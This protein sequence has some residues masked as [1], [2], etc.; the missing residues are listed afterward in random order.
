MSNE[1]QDFELPEDIFQREEIAKSMCELICSAPADAIS[2]VVLQGPWGSG[3]STHA[4]RMMEH[5]NKNYTETH[6]CIYWNA[7]SCDYAADPLP[8]FVANLYSE[9]AS[10]EQK[11][12]S[13]VGFKLCSSTAWA[14]S[15]ELVKQA[16]EKKYGLD[17]SK[18]E[19]VAQQ[20]QNETESLS[21]RQFKFF[22]EEAGA[23]KKRIDAAK[24][25]LNLARGDREL[26]VIIDELDR[27]RPDF[28]LQMIETI[29]H[30][31]TNE[32][33][34]FLLILNKQ[35]L[36]DSIRNIHGL[37]EINAE[38]YLNKFIKTTLQLPHL[39]LE[40][41]SSIDYNSQY[42]FH[43]MSN[44]FKFT[45]PIDLPELVLALIKNKK[46]QLR[47]IEKWVKTITN[48][49]NINKINSLENTDWPALFIIVII[50]YL[51]AFDTEL[52]FQLAEK[53]TKT[54]ELLNRL[55]INN[56]DLKIIT[57]YDR[58]YIDLRR[59]FDYYLTLGSPKENS[60]FTSEEEDWLKRSQITKAASFLKKWIQYSL[61][62]RSV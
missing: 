62:I 6:K 35:S 41:R 22:L 49:L 16:V 39:A 34:K 55:G 54:H 10:D 59:V 27:C 48:L 17:L 14:V 38:I 37:S 21:F 31:F 4:M 9:T 56:C 13:K 61:F 20:E 43:L 30:L 1:T 8:F 26:I 42:F 7:S 53:S 32:H 23:D 18:I 5:I 11:Q 12:F 57:T 2:P 29:K 36:L 52:A 60:F 24:E 51:I 28:A 50:S 19:E 3:K 47:E 58:Q 25:L 45:T 46:L 33:C 40:Y 15:K 44:R